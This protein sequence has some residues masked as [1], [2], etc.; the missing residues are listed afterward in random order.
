MQVTGIIAAA[1]LHP[2]RRPLFIP[3]G[4]WKPIHLQSFDSRA[5][6]GEPQT[7]P[8]RLCPSSSRDLSVRRRRPG[9]D[10]EH[11]SCSA[12]AAIAGDYFVTNGEADFRAA[13][14]VSADWWT[15]I[16]PRS[17]PSCRTAQ[18]RPCTFSVAILSSNFM[19]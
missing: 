11:R 9:D 13:K 1:D 8:A 5:E 16:S 10:T 4:P 18:P 2:F 12:V 7:T 17:M 14:P 19:L 15:Q 3:L 6:R